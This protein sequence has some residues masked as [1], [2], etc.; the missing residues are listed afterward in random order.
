LL[1]FSMPRCLCGKN[2]R[3]LQL[4]LEAAAQDDPRSGS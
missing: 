3:F 2:C 1:F 4:N